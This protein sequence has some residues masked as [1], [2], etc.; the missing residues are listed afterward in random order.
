[1]CAL[2]ALSG[3]AT[4]CSDDGDDSASAAETDDAVEVWCKAVRR[5]QN[6]ITSER[7][8]SMKEVA[9][10]AP[11]ELKAD[12]EIVIETMTYQQENPAD[13]V[14]AAERN[15]EMAEPFARIITASVEQ[16]GMTFEL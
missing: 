13:A 7:V 14:V 6:A 16:C 9:E 3:F 10:V 8:E 11:E 1:M 4:A 12:Y 5:S 15:Q 2:I